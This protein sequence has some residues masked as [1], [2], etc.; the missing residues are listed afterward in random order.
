MTAE[1]KMLAKL[2]EI[3]R[4]DKLS[5]SLEECDPEAADRAYSEMW[6]VVNEV[7]DTITKSTRGQITRPIALKMIWHKRPQLIDLCKRFS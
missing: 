4:L 6:K 2:N 5:E 1:K 7:A 3:D